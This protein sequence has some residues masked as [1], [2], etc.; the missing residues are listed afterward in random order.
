MIATPSFRERR[1]HPRIN[2]NIPVKLSY[3]DGG[4]VTET[5][6]ISRSGAYCCVKG[7]MKPMTKLKIHALVLNLKTVSYNLIDPSNMI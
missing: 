1:E 3:G 4:S 5:F 7:Y 6:N 2:S